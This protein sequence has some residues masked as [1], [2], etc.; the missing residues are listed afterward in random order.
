MQND[1]NKLLGKIHIAKKELGLDDDT[2]RSIIRQAV[3]K[4]S[5][6]KCTE[7]QLVKI[8]E[9]LRAKGWKTGEQ[10]AKK[11]KCVKI[12]PSIKK[13]YALW[14]ELQRSGKI[15][16]RDEAALNRFVAKYSTKNNV[17]RL[18]NAEAWKIIEILKKMSERE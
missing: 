13:I 9:L 5:A 3:G 12:S 17:R 1:R 10:P 14:G 8:I 6:A 16:S 11:A 15:K 18:T 2:Y 4:E 7:R